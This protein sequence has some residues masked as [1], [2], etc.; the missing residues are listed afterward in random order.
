MVNAAELRE[1]MYGV[2]A[3]SVRVEFLDEVHSGNR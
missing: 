1:A 2:N 3:S